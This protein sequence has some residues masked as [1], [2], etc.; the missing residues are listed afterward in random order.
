MSIIRNLLPRQT[1]TGISNNAN[2]DN[3]DNNDNNG[4]TFY[5]GFWYSNVRSAYLTAPIRIKIPPINFPSIFEPQ[6]SPFRTPIL[7][8]NNRQPT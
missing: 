7:T 3:N 5:D 8:L 6:N 4:G 2:N 1:N